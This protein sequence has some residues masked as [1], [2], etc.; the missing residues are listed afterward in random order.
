MFHTVQP[1]ETLYSIASRYGVSVEALMQANNLTDGM[2][3]VGQTLRIPSPGTAGFFPP[4]PFPPIPGGR[5]E[6]RV[7]RLERQVQSLE[8]QSS[9]MDRRLNSLEAEVNRLNQRVRRLEQG[10]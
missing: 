10:R 7:E 9:A 4:L 6:E 5:L 3:F 8:R 1:G 2:I